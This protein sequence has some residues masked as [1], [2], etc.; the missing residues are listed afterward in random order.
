MYKSVIGYKFGHPFDSIREWIEVHTREGNGKDTKFD[1]SIDDKKYKSLGLIINST[2]DSSGLTTYTILVPNGFPYSII[3]KR[4]IF[5]AFAELG[6]FLSTCHWMAKNNNPNLYSYIINRMPPNTSAQIPIVIYDPNDRASEPTNS[7]KLPEMNFGFVTNKLY[8]EKIERD[9]LELKQLCSN[10]SLKSIYVL[11]GSI[12]EAIIT[13]QLLSKK[14]EAIEIYRKR[15]PERKFTEDLS[16]WNLTD[17]IFIARSLGII[18]KQVEMLLRDL[19]DHR[20]IVH[21]NFEIDSGFVLDD[22]YA[23]SVLSALR[24]LSDY[25]AIKG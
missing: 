8:R 16:Y 15:L 20:N 12:I 23:N 21:I 17:K 24:K 13:D 18:P 2:E 1:G 7:I 14:G 6:K 11:T 10:G 19:K 22:T 5:T 3:Q 9:F 25:L 4:Q